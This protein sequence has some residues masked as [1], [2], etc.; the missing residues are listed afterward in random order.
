[1]A[2]IIYLTPIRIFYF[3]YAPFPW[4]IKRPGHLMGLFDVIFYLYLSICI[5]I[6]LESGSLGSND[7][8]ALR[9]PWAWNS[10]K[11]TC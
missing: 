5:N 9:R 10:A 1:M 7:P 6:I 8:P 2:E 4:D 11:P 3:L